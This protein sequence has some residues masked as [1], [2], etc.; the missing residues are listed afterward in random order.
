MNICSRLNNPKIYKD[1]KLCDNLFYIFY[2]QKLPFSGKIMSYIQFQYL[3]SVHSKLIKTCKQFFSQKRF[4]VVNEME[5]RDNAIFLDNKNISRSLEAMQ[6]NNIKIW[7]TEV[8]DCSCFSA[9]FEHASPYL[10]IIYRFDG[11]MLSFLGQKLSY[12]EYMFLVS[13]HNLEVIYLNRF[14]IKHSDGSLVTTETLLK[15]L[16]NVKDLTFYVFK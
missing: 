6:S 3:S 12:D 15:H 4:L 14:Q 5:T 16:I 9:M 10:K 11:K 7:I 13:P 8:L 1:D 2:P